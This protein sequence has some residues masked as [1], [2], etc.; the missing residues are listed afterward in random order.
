M[1]DQPLKPGDFVR[2]FDKPERCGIIHHLGDFFALVLF[3]DAKGRVKLGNF[4]RHTLRRVEAGFDPKTG[5]PILDSFW[6][7]SIDQSKDDLTLPPTGL[8]PHRCPACEGRGKIAEH[9][10]VRG[11]ECEMENPC[12]ACKGA[13]VLWG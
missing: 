9:I 11:A 12:P 8:V 3:W 5:V 1:T 2:V 10:Q 6:S 13:C 4:N 7:P